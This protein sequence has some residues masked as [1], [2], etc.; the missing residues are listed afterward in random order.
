MALTRLGLNQSINLASN[1]TGTL[2]TGNGG[3]GATSFAPGKVL[4]LVNAFKTDANTLTTSSSVTDV[5]N[6]TCSITPSSTS[7]F[8]YVTANFIYQLFG[9]SSTTTP[10]GQVLLLN[11]ADT[12]LAKNQFYENIPNN[13]HSADG[14]GTLEAYYNPSTTSQISFNL[15]I[16]ASAGR[17]LIYGDDQSYTTKPTQ[18]TVM[19]ISA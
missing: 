7:N 10:H 4:Q 19:E 13:D 16:L 14:Q 15:G 8:V 5:A 2:A 12:V 6:L 1:V 17:I 11:N 18:I 9:N 3:T